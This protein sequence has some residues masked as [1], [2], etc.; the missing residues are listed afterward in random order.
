[1][2][3]LFLENTKYTTIMIKPHPNLACKLLMGS[4][5]QNT[6]KIRVAPQQRNV[7]LNACLTGMC[8]NQGWGT[9]GPREFLI[10]PA[11]EFCLPKL[12]HNNASK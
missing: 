1:M 7:I 6:Q 3:Q 10:W 8:L 9:C 12:E 2:L 5:M 11:S 4:V